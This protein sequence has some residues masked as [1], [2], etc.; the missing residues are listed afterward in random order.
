VFC[1]SLDLKTVKR[2]KKRGQVSVVSTH[3][4]SEKHHE[5][6]INYVDRMADGHKYCCLLVAVDRPATRPLP[7]RDH[8]L[9]SGMDKSGSVLFCFD[10]GLGSLGSDWIGKFGYVLAAQL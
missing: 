8:A 7:C 1:R 2:R 6:Y 9:G 4:P 10:L 3:H 5:D